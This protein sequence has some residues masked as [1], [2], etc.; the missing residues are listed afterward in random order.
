MT[1]PCACSKFCPVRAA[2]AKF[3]T[4]WHPTRPWRTEATPFAPGEDI[5]TIGIFGTPG[6]VAPWM[7]G[8]GGV[9]S[10]E[11]RTLRVLAGENAKAFALLHALDP[12]Q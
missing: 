6:T 7:I 10:K 4:S 5:Y 3:W 2:T 12:A 11:G 9:F 1:R 8:F